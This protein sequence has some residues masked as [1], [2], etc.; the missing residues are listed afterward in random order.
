MDRAYWR[1]IHL[2]VVGGLPSDRP[3]SSASGALL[4]TAFADGFRQAAPIAVIVFRIEAA[5]PIAVR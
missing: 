1:S 2:R 4:D 5:F 3:I